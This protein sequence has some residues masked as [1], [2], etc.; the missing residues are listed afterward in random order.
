MLISIIIP[1]K[2]RETIFFL[3]LESICS[4]AKNIDAEIIV[5]NDS[6]NTSLKIPLSYHKVRL[7]DNPKSGV[8]SA[9]NLGASAAQAETLLFIDDDI[10]VD[11]ENLITAIKL[12][13][14][15]PCSTINLNW[16]YPEYLQEK[17]KITSFGRYLIKKGFT[18]LKGWNNAA[19][20]N[21]ESIFESNGITS[22]FLVIR[23]NDFLK[24]NGYNENFPFAGF[25]DYDF[26]KR[27][28][29]SG[30]KTYIYPL[31]MV[32]HNE[33]DRIKPRPWLQRNMRGGVSRRKAVEQGYPDLNI[34]QSRLKY[35]AYLIMVKCKPILF[36]LESIIPNHSVF[37]IIYF[38]LI[39]LL[40]GTSIFEGYNKKK[41]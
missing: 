5:V 17:I 12:I 19:N 37:D 24:I 28:K 16:T 13:D 2:E 41:Y 39:N 32:F 10:L 21:D 38:R 33:E 1:T 27:L 18:S 25:E 35:L 4:A 6:K 9:R 20:W 26:S 15:Y 14:K 29:K 8:A 31:S 40:L 3:T 11:E 23:K 7:F 30:V 34:I 22:Q 36:F